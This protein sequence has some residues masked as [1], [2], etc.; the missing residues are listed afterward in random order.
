M[1]GGKGVQRIWDEFE[2]ILTVAKECR[3]IE[4]VVVVEFLFLRTKHGSAAIERVK[5][6]LIS[7]WV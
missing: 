3:R 5:S 2:S 6:G 1:K 7:F 4:R